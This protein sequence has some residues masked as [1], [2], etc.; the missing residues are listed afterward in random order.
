V[1]FENHLWDLYRAET[2]TV[3]NGECV[4]VCHDYYVTA[5][6]DV[7]FVDLFQVDLY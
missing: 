6:V 5:H 1:L 7:E 4:T 3:K 2:I